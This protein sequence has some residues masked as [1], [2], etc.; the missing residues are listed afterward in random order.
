MCGISGILGSSKEIQ[1]QDM[2][3]AMAHRG[4]ND[5]GIWRDDGI[6]LGMARLS[7]LDVSESGHQPMSS[8]D[9]LIWMVYN[10]ETY[11]FNEQRAILERDGHKFVSH[12]DTEVVLRMYEVYGDD[13]MLRLR[14][15]FAFAIYDKRAGPGNERLILARDQLGIKPLL[16]THQAG[17]LIF[18]SELKAILA[19]GLV[20]HAVEPEALRLLLTFGSVTQPYTMIKGVKALLPAHRLIIERGVETVESYWQLAAGR[21]AEIA[22]LPYPEQVSLVR[23]SLEESVKLQMISDVP[24]GAFLSGG[25]DSSLLVALMARNSTHKVKTFS[26]GFDAEHAAMD[27]SGDAEKTAAF[28]GT[29]HTRVHVTGEQARDRIRH[30]ASSLDQPSVD[31]VNSYFVS[32]AAKQA[33]TVAISGTGGDELFAGYPWFITMVKDARKRTDRSFRACFAR[34]A[35]AAARSPILDFMATSRLGPRLELIRGAQGFVSQFS[36]IHQIFGNVGAATFLS[37]ANRGRSRAFVG[38]GA[39]RRAAEGCSP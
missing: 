39:S 20:D 23:D 30:I 32:L 24:L 26:V 25:V 18:S 36:R 17:R 15:M 28:V 6:A 37:T 34:Q 14:G 5:R 16:Y 8:L 21:R 27:E 3:S 12:S 10:G 4:P 7:V 38:F 29:D 31:G 2:V 19:S 11:N 22:A 13:F 1:I 9:G 35:S 33:V